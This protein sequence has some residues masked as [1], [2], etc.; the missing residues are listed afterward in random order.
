MDS[1][2]DHRDAC[3]P[4]A[5][6]SAAR[7]GCLWPERGFGVYLCS[8][9]IPFLLIGCIDR[10]RV[11]NVELRKKVQTLEAQIEQLNRR[12]D[13]DQASIKAL[14]SQRGT[15][16]NLP[17]DRIDQLVTVHGLKLGRLT[18]VDEKSVKVYAIPTDQQG[19]D[20]KAA[21]SFV[22][23]AFDPGHS[24]DAPLQRWEF[25]LEQSRGAWLGRALV[26][27]YVLDCPWKAPPGA[28][29]VRVKVT[30]TDA[31]TLRQFSVE[32]VVE[33]KQS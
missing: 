16:A 32:K 6:R 27:D 15:V 29:S 8:L 7:G 23:E 33:R 14:E 24:G 17:Q 5:R 11:A 19:Q 2:P 18:G 21:G 9:S 13:A 22:I 20:L 31:L 3:T 26:Y 1:G 12:H 4:P 28:G 30:F 10:T 25:N